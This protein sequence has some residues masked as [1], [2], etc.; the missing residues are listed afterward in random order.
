MS[1]ISD[2]RGTSIL[3][4]KKDQV[5]SY[6]LKKKLKN[7]EVL[8]AQISVYLEKTIGF[9]IQKFQLPT[10]PHQPDTDFKD[11]A[12]FLTESAISL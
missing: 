1:P 10:G 2:Y 9:P 7:I 8:R 5:K 6:W 12:R 11:L 4:D 3:D